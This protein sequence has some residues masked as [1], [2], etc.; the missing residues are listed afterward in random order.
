MMHSY[1]DLKI[2]PAERFLRHAEIVSLKGQISNLLVALDFSTSKENI[3]TARAYASHFFS[4]SN[5]GEDVMPLKELFKSRGKTTEDR[6]FY[7][8]FEGK[9]S[10]ILLLLR[11][12]EKGKELGKDPSVTE[13]KTFLISVEK[14]LASMVFEEGSRLEFNSY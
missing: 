13:A 8:E 1:E 6:E 9:M 14:N 5:R 11:D 4:M 3:D 10:K 2:S 12:I 7:S